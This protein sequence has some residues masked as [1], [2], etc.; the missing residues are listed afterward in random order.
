MQPA[1]VTPCLNS[2]N[3]AGNHVVIWRKGSTV[4]SAGTM[5]TT[6]DSRYRLHSSSNRLE[7]A[8][9]QPKDAGDYACQISTTEGT[10]EVSHTVEVLGKPA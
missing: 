3:L 5:L 7:L 10:L 2:S 9:I 6:R 4:L 8:N 1:K